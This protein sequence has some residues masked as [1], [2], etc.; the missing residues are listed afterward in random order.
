MK[1]R[2]MALA[3]A[4][5]IGATSFQGCIGNFVLTR[6]VLNFNQHISNKWVN[7]I[8][9]LIMV[10]IPVYGVCIFIDGIIL[11]SCEFWLG[12]NPLAMNEG[13]V[14][15]KYVTEGDTTYQI[16]ISKNRYHFLQI[17]GP[18]K[19]ESAD[20]FYNPETKTWSLGNGKINRRLV[21]NLNDKE[22]KVFT[23]SG[24]SMVVNRDS[25][26]DNLAS[27]LNGNM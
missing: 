13:Q 23:K 7:E 14:E 2:G 5:A 18:N 17:E 11:N 21:Q 27:V 20:L 12:T 8:V 4:L 10:I 1:K 3:L 22:M 26:P 15:T 25:N 6:K 16:D 9:F 19:G 24:D